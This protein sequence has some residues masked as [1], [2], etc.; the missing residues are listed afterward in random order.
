M[1]D[2]LTVDPCLR[3]I[4]GWEKK[5]DIPDESTFSRAFSEF[6]NSRLLERVHDVLVTRDGDSPLV[7]HIS[8]DST[9]IEARKKPTPKVDVV[10][11]QK[12]KVTI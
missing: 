10:N 3:R 8:R 12:Q 4:C 1:I 6:A 2:R 9:K 11:G 7:G 5:Q